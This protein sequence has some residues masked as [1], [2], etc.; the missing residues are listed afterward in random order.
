MMKFFVSFIAL[1]IV[2][3]SVFFVT[4]FFGTP[5]SKQ[6]ALDDLKPYCDEYFANG[7]EIE[8]IQ[9]S[10][11]AERYE[12]YVTNHIGTEYRVCRLENNEV[13]VTNMVSEEH[14]YL[15]A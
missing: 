15:S 5:Q 10:W 4:M 9:Y 7:Y 11:K 14:F 13:C 1:A 8:E 3:V 6:E 12:I 2:S